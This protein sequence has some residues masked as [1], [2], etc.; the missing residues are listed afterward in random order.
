VDYRA[1]LKTVD[2]GAPPDVALLHGAEPFL[3]QEAVERVSRTLFGEGADLALSREVLDAREVGGAAIVQSALMLPWAGG[4]RLVIARG[5]EDLSAKSAEP[6]GAYGQAP[7]SSTV[8]LLLAGQALSPAHPLLK[9][10]PRSAVVLVVAPTGRELATW[11]RERF[12]SRG[13]ELTAEAAS[14]LVD[15]VGDD[16]TQLCGE[17]EKAALWA[18]ADT[19]RVGATEIRA[20]VGET[21]VRHVFDLT[22]AI[23][24]GD[25]GAALGLLMSLLN[26][27]EDPFALLGML[28]REAR[29]VW[30]AADALARG[31]P[32]EDVA[33]GLGRPPGA[34]AAM[35]ARARMV[36]PGSAARLLRRCWEAERRLKLGGAPRPE[37]ALLVSDLCA[38]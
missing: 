3:I 32:E 35:I 16:L 18:G 22:R 19:R 23:V 9:L 11:L 2:A 15:L 27:G 6:L 28:S 1:F 10:V 31:R 14:L 30:Q 12:R 4:R 24:A 25:S 8:L 17:V 21:R 37:L 38:G 5:V 36:S 34:A 29:A 33:R 7:N 26:S 20:V 13:V